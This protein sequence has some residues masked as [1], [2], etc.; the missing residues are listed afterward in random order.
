MHFYQLP[1][2]H[3]DC[4]PHQMMNLEVPTLWNESPV[5]QI[6]K[7]KKKENRPMFHWIKII[8]QSCCKPK[9]NNYKQPISFKPTICWIQLGSLKWG[10]SAD[11]CVLAQLKIK[12]P[13][14]ELHRTGLQL[15]D[16]PIFHNVSLLTLFI[17]QVLEMIGGKC[18]SLGE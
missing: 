7:K 16:W 9:Q 18:T 5:K 11:E 10:C 17:L 6:I 12:N 3:L 1:L 4:I 14:I 8:A 15:K 2:P 13:F